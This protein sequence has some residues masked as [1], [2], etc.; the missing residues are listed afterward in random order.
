LIL[1]VIPKEN[2]EKCSILF[3]TFNKLRINTL[4]HN[5]RQMLGD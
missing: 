4:Q 2:E 1:Q 3:D 5:K